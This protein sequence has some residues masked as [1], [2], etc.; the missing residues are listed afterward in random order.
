MSKYLDA[1]PFTTY[2]IH[3]RAI[4]PSPPNL[5]GKLFLRSSGGT[6]NRTWWV[7]KK[8]A[9]AFTNASNGSVGRGVRLMET[10]AQDQTV[11]YRDFEHKFGSNYTDDYGRIY[12]VWKLGFS[13]RDDSSVRTTQTLCTPNTAKTAT[14]EVTIGGSGWIQFPPSQP[15]ENPVDF[16]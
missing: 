8:W 2:P 9:Y 11:N 16:R 13:G 1:T 3:K 15:L 4:H 10:I 5:R 14:H 6:P 12:D 7:Y